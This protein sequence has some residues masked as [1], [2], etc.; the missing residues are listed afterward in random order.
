M[1][2]VTNVEK[3]YLVCPYDPSHRLTESS[4]NDHLVACQWKTEGYGRLDVPLS[5]PTL[6]ADSPF[7]IKFDKQLQERV[8][9]EAKEQNPAMQIGMGE[10]L[11]PHTS[12]RVVID[13]TSD[14]RKALYDYVIANT[15]KP[16]IGEDI[17]SMNNLEPQ[18]KEDKKLSF[19]ELLIQERNLKRRRAK[20]RGVHTN[21]KSHTEILRE[22]IGQQMEMYVEYI[23]GESNSACTTDVRDTKA[24][25]ASY[26]EKM[27][28]RNEHLYKIF[29][30][31]SRN[32]DGYNSGER[33][34]HRHKKK[35]QR[36]D[37]S[38]ERSHRRSSDRDRK[39]ERNSD[40][41]DR[42]RKREHRKSS[43]SSEQKSHKKDKHR[44]RDKRKDKYHE[45]KHKSRDRDKSSERHSKHSDYK[46]K[47]RS[48]D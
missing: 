25:D 14:E 18:Q 34:G 44:S 37:H 36:G 8:L 21:K 40:K 39:Q 7:C 43:H 19:L 42:K 33:N 10:R 46:R 22:V 1:E 11:V 24:D 16:D 28:D 38:E 32:S 35:D 30:T 15:A 3:E 12:D 20:H 2:S 29:H 23:S 13:F 26:C 27:Q 17:A 31:P 48:K 6:P 9:R 4:L 45:K 47:D 41:T 5:E